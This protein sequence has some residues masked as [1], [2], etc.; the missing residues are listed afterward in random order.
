MAYNFIAGKDN[1]LCRSRLNVHAVEPLITASCTLR[2][3][4]VAFRLPQTTIFASLAT[5]EHVSISTHLFSQVAQSTTT[6]HQVIISMGR[7]SLT[8]AAMTPLSRL[9]PGLSSQFGSS[10]S[11][12]T[13]ALCY[14]E[15]EVSSSPTFLSSILP[16]IVCQTCGSP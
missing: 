5:P 15:T 11:M 7:A 12:A 16:V 9:I 2:S 3:T 6:C 14:P 10:A 8:C 1:S 4:L 13:Q